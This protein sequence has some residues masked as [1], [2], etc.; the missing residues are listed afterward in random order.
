MKDE[1]KKFRAK[2]RV[3]HDQLGRIEKGQ[4]FEATPQ[5]MSTIGQYCDEIETVKP[6]KKSKS[7]D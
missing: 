7:A 3:Y 5:Q 6:A 4:E 1:K 2:T